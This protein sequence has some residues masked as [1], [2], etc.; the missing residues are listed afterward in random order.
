MTVAN[1]SVKTATLIERR[2]RRNAENKKRPQ[3]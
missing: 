3:K 1:S 2:Y